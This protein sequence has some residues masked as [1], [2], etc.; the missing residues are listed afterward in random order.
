VPPFSFRERRGLKGRAAQSAAW[1]GVETVTGRSSAS[2]EK[3]RPLPSRV[4]AVDVRLQE[5]GFKT[6]LGRSV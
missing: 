3:S 1:K 6:K 2:E 4:E 5:L